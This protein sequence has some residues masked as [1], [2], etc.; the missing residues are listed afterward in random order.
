MKTRHLRFAF[1][2]GLLH[3]RVVASKTQ[4]CVNFGRPDPPGLGR[5]WSMTPLRISCWC[6]SEKST[7]VRCVAI[8]SFL[9]FCPHKPPYRT[10]NLLVLCFT[11]IACPLA[12]LRH[13]RSSSSLQSAM[14]SIF[15]EK[16]FPPLG[17]GATLRVPVGLLY[18]LAG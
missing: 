12:R 16:D 7:V 15:S 4:T 8:L 17:G 14:S 1:W 5:N 9:L 10:D 2:A 11:Y 6:C 13:S 18:T 3:H